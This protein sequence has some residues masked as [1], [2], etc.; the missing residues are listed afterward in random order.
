[1]VTAR[2]RASLIASNASFTASASIERTNHAAV[3]RV[4]DCRAR[5]L[6]KSSKSDDG[7][8]HVVDD[9]RRASRAEDAR[10]NHRR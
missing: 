3:S 4:V 9:D 1:M 8:A 2:L 5:H 10:G 6:E 7:T